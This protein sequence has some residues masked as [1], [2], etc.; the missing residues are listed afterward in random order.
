MYLRK[1]TQ[2]KV[3]LSEC[4]TK[5]VGDTT[6]APLV[7]YETC[8]SQFMGSSPGCVPLSASSII[9]YRPGMVTFCGWE[10][11]RKS[12]ITLV[13]CHRLSDISTYRL[14]AKGREMNTVPRG[15][16]QML[17]VRSCIRPFDLYRNG[18]SLYN[19]ELPAIIL[20]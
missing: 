7:G 6:I 8:N 19:L 15:V 13:M 4:I 14:M 2:F 17:L 1:H 9:W 11:N 12:G 20:C 16:A 3:Q 10:G 5:T 18:W